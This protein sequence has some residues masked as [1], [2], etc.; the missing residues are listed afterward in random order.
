[1]PNIIPIT[2][3]TRVSSRVIPAPLT[4]AGKELIKRFIFY[5]TP[6]INGNAALS[7]KRRAAAPEN[8]RIIP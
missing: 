3:A 8:Q 7:I 2:I 1:M 6:S 5:S 4:N